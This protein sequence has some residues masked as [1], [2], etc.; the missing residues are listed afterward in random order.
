MKR[1]LYLSIIVASLWACKHTTNHDEAQKIIN[2]AQSID[3]NPAELF[4]LVFIKLE[5]NDNSLVG[6][7]VAQ[8]EVVHEKLIILTGGRHIN[9]LVFDLSGKFD[10]SIGKVGR[11]PG[12]YIVPI[13]F[14]INYNDNVIS[15]IDIAQ[16]KIISYSLDNYKFLFDNMMEYDS[17]C[18]EFLSNDKILWKNANY[19][20]NMSDWNFIITDLKQHFLNKYVRRDFVTGYFTGPTKSIYKSEE[21]VFAYTQYNP[22]IYQFFNDEVIPAYKIK[23]GK[24]QLPPLE[25]LLKVSTNNNNFIAELNASNYISYYCVFDAAN[26]LGIFYSVSQNPYIGIFDKDKK[27]VYHYSKDNFQDMLKIGEM[28]RPIGT[29]GDYVVSMLYPSHLLEKLTEGYVLDKKLH[30]MVSE[31]Q[32]D[33]NPFLFL[34]KLKDIL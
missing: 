5:T 1:Y 26:T 34:F 32:V 25:Y 2:F 23:F 6:N 11:G 8:I 27:R 16:K 20:D 7:F 24:H 15:V 19:Q 14:S 9:L 33:D 17:F 10:R 31:S 4:E 22:I 21:T 30:S 18:F 12:E 28:E 3:E 29:I 13:S